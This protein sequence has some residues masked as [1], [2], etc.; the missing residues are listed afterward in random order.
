MDEEKNF[1]ESIN[2]T[3]NIDRDYV[4]QKFDYEWLDDGTCSKALDQ[5]GNPKKPDDA[6]TLVKAV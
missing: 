3:L 1:L 4:N 2:A 5:L 6:D